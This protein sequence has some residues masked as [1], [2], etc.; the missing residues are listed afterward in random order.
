MVPRENQIS[1][2]KYKGDHFLSLLL[3]SLRGLQPHLD[4]EAFRKICWAQKVHIHVLQDRAEYLQ[5]V[6]N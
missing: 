6:N 5:C 2:G 3:Y 4:L 1:S